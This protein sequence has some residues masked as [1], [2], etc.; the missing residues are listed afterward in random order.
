MKFLLNFSSGSYCTFE[1]LLF[2]TKS[3]LHV[4]L[5]LHFVLVL[6][7]VAEA[8]LQQLLQ[9]VFSVESRTRR[10]EGERE[11]L[12][13]QARTKVGPQAPRAG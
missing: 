12:A 9:C 11:L 1:L 8:S 3:L 5:S 2:F 7:L 13:R 10:Y 4:V 6:Q